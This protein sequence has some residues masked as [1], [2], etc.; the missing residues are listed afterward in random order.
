[1]GSAE[2]TEETRR[3]VVVNRTRLDAETLKVKPVVLA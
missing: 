2:V 3:R 1:M